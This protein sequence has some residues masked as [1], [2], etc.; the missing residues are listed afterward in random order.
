MAASPNTIISPTA[1]SFGEEEYRHKDLK[2]IE[3]FGVWCRGCDRCMLAVRGRDLSASPNSKLLIASSPVQ[4]GEL[5][6]T[7]CYWCISTSPQSFLDQPQQLLRT[8]G[9]DWIHM[10]YVADAL[11]LSPAY[12]RCAGITE[13]GMMVADVEASI[14]W[15]WDILAVHVAHIRVGR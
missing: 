10:Q 6:L 4:A 1:E 11:E 3:R 5:R 7:V 13:A 8:T 9:Y 2:K 14:P 12:D 15:G